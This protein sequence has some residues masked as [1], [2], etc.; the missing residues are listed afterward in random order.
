MQL[1][2]KPYNL[3]TAMKTRNINADTISVNTDVDLA[4]SVELIGNTE[5][6]LLF[7]ANI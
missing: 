5:L 6:S 4:L 3:T 1:N 7:T 2:L